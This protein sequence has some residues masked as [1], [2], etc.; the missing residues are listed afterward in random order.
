MLVTG[1]RGTWARGLL[2]GAAV[3][4]LA[5][6]AIWNTPEDAVANSDPSAR[7]WN[8]AR[9]NAARTSA[10]AVQPVV[11]DPVEAWRTDLGGALLSDP[12][13][14][15]GTVYVVA[16]DGRNPYLHA[17]AANTGKTLASRRLTSTDSV[18][19]AVWAGTVIV[20]DDKGKA[21]AQRFTG[22]GF[23]NAWTGKFKAGGAVAIHDGFVF[24]SDGDE[25]QIAN[26]ET[27]RKSVAT[28]GINYDDI[29][30]VGEVKDLRKEYFA[31]PTA[32]YVDPTTEETRV[33]TVG[34][35]MEHL[36]LTE[37]RA[38][39][40]D[41]RKAEL[42]YPRTR[43]IARTKLPLEK[44]QN[45]FGTMLARIQGNAETKSKGGW[46]VTTDI[47]LQGSGSAAFIDDA[48][49]KGGGST[50]T[51]A[52]AVSG[53]EAF[54]FDS[55]GAMRRR[56]LERGGAP[57]MINAKDLPKGAQ[58]G[59]ATMAGGT[60]FFGNW[61]FDPEG[62]RVLWVRPD[63][64]PST[65]AIPVGDGR[66]VFGTENS[67]V[68][69]AEREVAEASAAAAAAAE[70]GEEIEER[71][72]PE[73]PKVM[74]GVL[75]VDGRQ[76]EGDFDFH[77]NGTVTIK[78]TEGD[79]FDIEDWKVVVARRG[80][81]IEPGAEFDAYN[82]WLD[83]IYGRY[84]EE[85]TGLYGEYAESRL[86]TEARRL[87]GIL[88]KYELPE[89]KAN[90]LDAELTG[91]REISLAD[92]KWEKKY[93]EREQAVH[94]AAFQRMVDGA[95]WCAEHGMPTAATVLVLDAIDM[96]PDRKDELLPTIEEWIPEEAFFHGQ[97]G[98]RDQWATWARE[99]L[100]AS[101]Q[102][103]GES[104]GVWRNVRNRPWTD[105]TALAFRTP[106]LIVMCMD[107]RPTINGEL[108][109]YGE[110]TVQLAQALLLDG[111]R[112][113]VRDDR[114]RMILLV[115]ESREAYLAERTPLGQASEWSAGYY[116]PSENLSRF[117][118]PDRG[119]DRSNMEQMLGTLAHELTHHYMSS[120]WAKG[121]ARSSGGPGFWV[122]EGMAELLEDQATGMSRRG[123]RV[124][125]K[126]AE[127]L[128]I[129]NKV[130]STTTRSGKSFYFPSQRFVDM[131]QM[132]FGSQLGKDEDG[133]IQ[134][135]LSNRTGRDA[136]R[137]LDTRGV[138]YSQAG[139]LTFFFM[140]EV[141]GAGRETFVEYIRLH[142]QGRSPREGWEMLGF[143]SAEELDEA[144]RAFLESLG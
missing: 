131:T 45:L 134:V 100:P 19:L 135:K 5:V 106:N 103:V 142:Y 14:W 50:L 58:V 42:D 79:E 29:A 86:L 43:V 9:G 52:M 56:S 51:R 46:L 63:D 13:T 66:M 85:L 132:D 81:F 115:H 118:V 54:G 41:S 38:Q 65:A 15:S 30:D 140:N 116:S 76:V 12:V 60:L 136:M 138:W 53:F 83:A 122:V 82:V 34:Y 143:E 77:S 113:R 74:D 48:A 72:V 110:G 23:N 127:T 61:A 32:V 27:G 26:A 67:L 137:I 24:A 62:G 59:P 20:I 91:Q 2:G 92:T 28:L 139:A 44:N 21:K 128:D 121:G 71:S 125:D 4:G 102:F 37:L 31:G 90:A 88:R 18:S 87:L 80:D 101:A 124:D 68:C 117:Y 16:S 107:R 105:R 104:E 17:I 10:S 73:L 33:V 36:L 123:L 75:L 84:R 35:A 49:K 108:V 40:L 93:S 97:A 22:D 98:A 111:A 109:R 78:P 112:D 47:E 120:R 144:F 64:A 89:S 141:G 69:I 133:K 3:V 70:S 6:A 25:I 119:N 129:M 1:S 7:E 55:Q 114:D 95:K 57:Q 96:Q 8:Q 126:R 11:G 99:L 130:I 94:D 39:N